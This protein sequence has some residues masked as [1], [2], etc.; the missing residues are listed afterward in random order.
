MPKKLTL[1]FSSEEMP[2]LV[3]GLLVAVLRMRIAE[4]RDAIR[5]L[6]DDPL[7]V[8]SEA[9]GRHA[10]REAVKWLADS[11]PIHLG[12]K[13]VDNLEPFVTELVSPGMN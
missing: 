5:I 1:P 12:Q 8:L 6:A 13:L 7:K 2:D 9:E 11:L 4:Q 10:A 3:P